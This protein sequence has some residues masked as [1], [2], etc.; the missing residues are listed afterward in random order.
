MRLC[1]RALIRSLRGALLLVCCAVPLRAQ[2][3]LDGRGTEPLL[4]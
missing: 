3:L 1:D 2:H 4:P